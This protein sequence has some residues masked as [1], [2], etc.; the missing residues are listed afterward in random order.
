ML[1]CYFIVFGI[2]ALINVSISARDLDIILE[3]LFIYFICQSTGYNG[4]DTCGK[5]RDELEYYLKPELNAV[6]YILLGLLP[7]SNL[8]FAVQVRDVKTAIQK[9][10]SGCKFHDNST[11]TVNESIH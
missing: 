6:T 11:S 4:P 2:T 3:K 1:S 8:L 7:W 9:L 5:E 10:L